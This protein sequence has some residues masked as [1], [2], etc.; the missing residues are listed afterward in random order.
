ML[1]MFGLAGVLCYIMTR[2][3]LV[4]EYIF[5]AKLQRDE[6]SKKPRNSDNYITL[7]FSSS[8]SY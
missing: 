8:E 3:K 6:M 7:S 4:S 5:N 1:I 2:Q